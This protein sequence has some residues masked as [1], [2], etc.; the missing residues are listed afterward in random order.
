LVDEFVDGKPNVSRDLSQKNRRDV[1]A[2]M[3]RDR[4]S[5][6]IQVSILPVRTPLANL[7]EPESF[8]ESRHLAWL[9]DW[10]ASQ[11]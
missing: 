5:A 4:R 3:E 9:Q 10:N 1:S 2:C 11:L 7:D 8:Q 6:T